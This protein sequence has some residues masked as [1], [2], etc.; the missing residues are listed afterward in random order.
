M[1]KIRA[2]LW[3]TACALCSLLLLSGC[4]WLNV[5]ENSSSSSTAPKNTVNI[6]VKVKYEGKADEGCFAVPVGEEFTLRAYDT[7]EYEFAFWERAQDGEPIFD[8]AEHTVTAKQDTTY[9][10]VFAPKAD[11]QVLVN[12]VYERDFYAQQY[13]YDVGVLGEGYQ[14]K[15]EEVHLVSD[16]E[17]PVSWF[18][19]RENWLYSFEEETRGPT[20]T[21]LPEKSVTVFVTFEQVCEIVLADSPHYTLYF[22]DG[23]TL[24][25]QDEPFSVGMHL[26]DGYVAD[27]WEIVW[28]PIPSAAA[29]GFCVNTREE[30]IN[31]GREWTYDWQVE[32]LCRRMEF[33]LVVTNENL[34]EPYQVE[35]IREEG[36]E[37]GMYCTMSIPDYFLMDATYNG[38]YMGIYPSRNAYIKDVKVRIERDDGNPYYQYDIINAF[39]GEYSG[40]YFHIPDAYDL[41]SYEDITVQVELV[42]KETHAVVNL[43]SND[44]NIVYTPNPNGGYA[45][46]ITTQSFVVKKGVSKEFHM[47]YTNNLAKIYEVG[48]QFSHIA[49]AKGNVV[50]ETIEFAYTP[51]EDTD[52]YIHYERKPIA[53]EFFDYHLSEEGDGYEVRLS[54]LSILPYSNYEMEYQEELTIPSTYNG[55]PVVEIPDFGM[56]YYQVTGNGMRDTYGANVYG[57]LYVPASIK[58]IGEKAFAN[59]FETKIV[60][61]EKAVFD[62]I[63]PDA[64]YS[65]QN[66]VKA[67]MTKAQLESVV[68]GL[69]EQYIGVADGFAL[70][71]EPAE[72]FK[73]ENALGHYEIFAEYIC[74]LA[75]D[76]DLAN[77]STYDFWKIFHEFAHHYQV[78]AMYGVGEET[79]ESLLIKPTQEDVTA[80]KQDYDKEDY[81]AYWTHPMEVSARAFAAKWTGLVVA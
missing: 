63:S 48:Y 43:I 33:S 42:S 29:H 40:G 72:H 10:A 7:D 14:R 17:L 68:K 70:C 56:S 30:G 13:Y 57:T 24:M 80:W 54:Q 75:D 25:N 26:E 1:K 6:T 50:S 37:P 61:D 58:R 9:Y 4:A 31:W 44:D 27:R 77:I 16:G 55:L 3:I 59:I 62:E 69:H 36:H 52:L 39:H 28:Y 32:S 23:D 76:L 71:L 21:L 67:N 46:S 22:K 64:F 41:G 79:Y 49:D 35:V 51:T 65:N 47:H 81:D 5:G 20:L 60:F 11:D 53:D 18:T 2:I 8:E 15:G 19:V 12:V 38:Y 74:I 34:S 66:S 73:D 45:P 78:V